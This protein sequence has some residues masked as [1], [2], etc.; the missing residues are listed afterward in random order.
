MTYRPFS[1]LGRFL[2]AACAVSLGAATLGAQTPA[3]ASGSNPSKVDVFLGYSYFGAHGR[4]QPEGIPYASVNLGAMGSVAYYMN[5]YFG[6]EFIYV[7]HPDGNNDGVSSLAVGP[8]VRYPMDHFTVFAHA[9]VGSE[10]L[11]GPNNDIPSQFEHNPYTWG[12]ALHAGGGMDYDLPFYDNRISLR[13]FQVDYRY[14]HDDF[15]P[16]A[17]IPTPGPVG[18][19]TNLEAIELSTGLLMHFG[20]QIP[21]PPVTYSC[22]V[23]PS[24][25]YPGDPIT[26][27]GTALNL[28]PKKTA[29]Y[30][31]NST[32][33][34]GNVY[35]DRPRDRRPE[36]GPIGRLHGAVHHQRVPAAYHQL[37]GE[38]VVSQLGWFFHDY[39]QRRKP[40][41]SSSHL[42]LQFVGR[43]H[44]RHHF[45]GYADHSATF[46]RGKQYH[47][48][49]DLQPG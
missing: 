20:H 2:L 42:Q 43:H 14:M 27:T 48:R 41:E 39:G 18:G 11:G 21:P 12:V 4:V 16:F 26:V 25:G 35:G 32:G 30:T 23:S 15:G 33:G 46:S 36:A 6:A 49:G 22:A 10:R 7:D 19:R 31:W 8:I 45:D 3:P 5:R 38:S 9:G 44:R 29:T 1:G 40:A 37:L 13:L 34:A 28:N 24:S 47:N 17:G